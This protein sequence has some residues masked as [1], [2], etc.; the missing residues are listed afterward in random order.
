[1]RSWEELDPWQLLGV[2]PDAS[3]EEIRNAY[4]RL[5]QAFAPGALALYSVADAEEQSRLQR[6]LHVAYQRLLRAAGA[7][8]PAHLEGVAA[9]PVSSATRP[10]PASSPAPVTTATPGPRPSAPPPVVAA[11]NAGNEVTGEQLREVREAWGLTLDA[12]ARRTRIPRDQLANIEGEVF[13]ALPAR[14][15]ARGFVMSYARELRLDP[16]LVWRAFERRWQ[17]HA[18]IPRPDLPRL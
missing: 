2:A 16:E 6:Q 14:V 1:M 5:Q 17:T 7:Q 18:P 10:E 11:V 15:F 3:V 9:P 8:E 4:H 13:A 12:V